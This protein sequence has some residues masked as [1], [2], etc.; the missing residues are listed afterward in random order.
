MRLLQNGY[1]TIAVICQ[2]FNVY[3][4]VLRST[5]PE[6][7]EVVYNMLRQLQ[8]KKQVTG[9]QDKHMRASLILAARVIGNANE[10]SSAAAMKKLQASVFRR[11]HRQTKTSV[12]GSHC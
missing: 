5:N 2:Q 11:Q 1:N 9:I 12:N 8:G 6:R 7:F 10:L 4:D 3:S